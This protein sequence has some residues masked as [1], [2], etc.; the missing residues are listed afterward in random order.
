MQTYCIFL[1]SSVHEGEWSIS[2]ISRPLY[3]CR[4]SSWHPLLRGSRGLVWTLEKCKISASY[5]EHNPTI[6]QR[7][8]M[9]NNIPTPS[10]SQ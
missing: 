8:R 9:P 10:F 3:S 7:S 1:T 5:W 2:F 6:P 4:K